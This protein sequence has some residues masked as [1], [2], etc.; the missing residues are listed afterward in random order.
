MVEARSS[1]LRS[2]PRPASLLLAAPLYLQPPQSRG[3]WGGIDGRG[4]NHLRGSP[5]AAG[6]AAAPRD[7][8]RG[9][10]VVPDKEASAAAVWGCLCLIARI[11]PGEMALSALLGRVG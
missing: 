4:G 10:A 1:T 2:P 9:T 8:W 6:P 5:C 11:N 3:T 7:E